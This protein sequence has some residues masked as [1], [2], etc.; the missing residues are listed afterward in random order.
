MSLKC[1]LKSI[2][3]YNTFKNHNSPI[4]NNG[5]NLEYQERLHRL[6][7]PTLAF[8]RLRGDV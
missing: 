4:K 8:R 3:R 7:L 2:D 1:V 5:K 6:N